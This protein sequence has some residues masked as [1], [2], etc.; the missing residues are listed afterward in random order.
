MKTFAGLLIAA[1]VITSCS[2]DKAETVKVRFVTTGIDVTQFKFTTGA[3]VSDKEVPFS[4]ME[5]TTIMVARG[6]MV[7]LDSKANSSN[8][9]GQIFVNDDQVVGGTDTDIDGDGKSQVKIE[10]SIPK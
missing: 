9:A 4:G 8:L 1:F 10:Y 6:T 7:K 5:D 2:K 3:F